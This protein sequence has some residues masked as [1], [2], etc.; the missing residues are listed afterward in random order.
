MKRQAILCLTTLTIGLAL[1]ACGGSGWEPET[2]EGAQPSPHEVAVAAATELEERD[3]TIRRFFED[4]HAFAIYP[5][6][7]KGGAWLGGAYGRGWVYRQGQLIGYTSV[8]QLTAGVQLGGQAYS[9]VI[10]FRDP[11][12]LADFTDGNYELGAQ[13]SAIAVTAGAAATA[14]YDDGVAVF[15]A[16]KGGLMYEAAVA[17]Q[18]FHYRPVREKTDGAS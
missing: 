10:F 12:A 9:E 17:G 16:P 18:K 13:A 1:P 2:A 14:A 7:G 11:A 4:A 6:V 3:P 15:T 8:T 5:T